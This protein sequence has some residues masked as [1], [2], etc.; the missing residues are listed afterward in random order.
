MTR[1][2]SNTRTAFTLIE[3]LVVI[4]I[5]ALLIGIL[6]PA[7]QSAR[8][9]ARVVTCGSNQRQLGIAFSAFAADNKQLLPWGF[10]TESGS[11]SFSRAWDDY[12]LDGY[13]TD[14]P[15]PASQL[16]AW[17]MSPGDFE[18]SSMQCP[19]DDAERSSNVVPRSYHVLSPRMASRQ[20]GWQ[21]VYH[22]LFATLNASNATQA[23]Q[24][25]RRQYSLDEALAASDTFLLSEVS[26]HG[27]YVGVPFGNTVQSL[28]GSTNN[29][30]LDGYAPLA[31]PGAVNQTRSLH[32]EDVN[33]LYADG[34][35]AL[36][37]P[38]S[39]VGTGNPNF[40]FGAW[41]R[42]TGD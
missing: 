20:S 14:N 35:V 33:Y 10:F 13:L 4:S 36:L 27:N 5:I 37:D 19:S 23:S 34:H 2:I 41:T 29:S 42:F 28:S 12:L 18:V 32:N 11:G 25:D 40:P 7:L 16:D 31:S 30:Q 6:L 26:G 1:F 22:G 21:T 38:E 17:F 24:A 3:L 15:L 9:T 39:T 8:E